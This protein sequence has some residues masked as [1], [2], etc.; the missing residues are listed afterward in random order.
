MYGGS[1]KLKFL[2]TAKHRQ[3]KVKR[4]RNMAEGKRK[5]ELMTRTITETPRGQQAEQKY[6]YGLNM[7][8]QS[9]P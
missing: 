8:C 7:Y 2:N 1:S 9:R 4:K 3:S 6:K 5:L